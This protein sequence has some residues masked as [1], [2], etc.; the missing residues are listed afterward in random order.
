M[1][2]IKWKTYIG[3]INY[4]QAAVS[5]NQTGKAQGAGGTEVRPRSFGCSNKE[6][7]GRK[8]FK[9]S[10]QKGKLSRKAT[11]LQTR[12]SCVGQGVGKT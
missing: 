5:C 10:V 12:G 1:G 6:N 3:K 8:T 9:A 4:W 7:K 11:S 2:K